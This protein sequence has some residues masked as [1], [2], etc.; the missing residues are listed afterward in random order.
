MKL[1][2]VI[3][4]GLLVITIQS[5]ILTNWLIGIEDRLDVIEGKTLLEEVQAQGIEVKK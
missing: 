1:L 3:I 5:A 2:W 4:G